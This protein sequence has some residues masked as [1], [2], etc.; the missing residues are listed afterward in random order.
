VRA[1]EAGLTFRPLADTVKATMEFYASQ[2]EARR[3]ELR[4]GLPAARE[5]EVLAAWRAR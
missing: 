3:A 2:P 4:A 5:K 1:L